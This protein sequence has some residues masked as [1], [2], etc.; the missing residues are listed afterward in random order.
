[1]RE[2]LAKIGWSI[3]HFA[4]VINEPERTVRD[5]VSGRSKTQASRVATKYLELVAKRLSA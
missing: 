5:W 1:M 2:L 4:T 3:R